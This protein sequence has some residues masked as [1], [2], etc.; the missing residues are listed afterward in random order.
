M[1]K[2]DWNKKRRNLRQSVLGLSRVI[3]QQIVEGLNSAGNSELKATHTTLLSNLDLGGCTISQVAAKAD[4][5]K[6]AMGRLT[7]ELTSLG[8]IHVESDPLDKRSSILLFTEEGIELMQSSFEIM[9]SIE[10]RCAE[11]VGKK[12]YDG[13]VKHLTALHAALGDSE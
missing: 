5:S 10:A 13:F 2:V 7:T 4:I 9:E 6:Q 11:V 3:N 8:Y 1:K 12:Q